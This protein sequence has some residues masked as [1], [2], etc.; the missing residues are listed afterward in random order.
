MGLSEK[1][2]RNFA[3][4]KSAVIFYDGYRNGVGFQPM[5]ALPNDYAA[6]TDNQRQR[7][8]YGNSLSL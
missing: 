7:I 3:D 8:A 4:E 5:L 2:R 6:L 1:Q